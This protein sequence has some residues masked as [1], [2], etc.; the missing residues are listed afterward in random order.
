M[1]YGKKIRYY[2][3]DIEGNTYKRLSFKHY[4]QKSNSRVVFKEQ[5]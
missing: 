2:I 1:K 3:K 4:N 5:K